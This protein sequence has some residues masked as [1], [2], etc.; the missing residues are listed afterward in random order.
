MYISLDRGDYFCPNKS[1][2]ILW[3]TSDTI[4]LAVTFG[5]KR[6]VPSFRKPDSSSDIHLQA[7]LEISPLVDTTTEFSANHPN[8]HLHCKTI[9]KFF[10]RAQLSVNLSST[11]Y[12]CIL[13]NAYRPLRWWRLLRLS[14]I[15]MIYSYEE[16]TSDEWTA[17][18]VQSLRFMGVKSEERQQAT[19]APTINIYK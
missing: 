1:H 13:G 14:P 12:T 3:I 5:Y 9:S 11:L 6:S 4:P 18:T 17:Y 7:R 8:A 2:R 10:V 19:R 16:T 15:C